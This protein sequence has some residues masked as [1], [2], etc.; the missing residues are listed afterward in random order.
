M[1]GWY[2]SKVDIINQKVDIMKRFMDMTVKGVQSIDDMFL[3]WQLSQGKVELP[4]SFQEILQGSASQSA[5]VEEFSSGLFNPTR[6][7]NNVAFRLS[8]RNRKFMANIT[9]PGVD[10]KGF[11]D[12]ANRVYD[13]DNAYA[14]EQA[15]NDVGG[16]AMW[17][18]G[19]IDGGGASNLVPRL[20]GYGPVAPPVGGPP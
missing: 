13:A 15:H 16:N 18:I 10:V 20:A 14:V 11:A 5:S 17:R 6:W 8:S 4:Q 9:I 12:P 7:S 19:N 3:L 2:Q 1:P